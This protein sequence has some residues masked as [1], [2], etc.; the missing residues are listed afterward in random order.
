VVTRIVEGS[1]VTFSPDREQVSLRENATHEVLHAWSPPARTGCCAPGTRAAIFFDEHE[2]V[3]DWHCRD[4][5]LG[6]REDERPSRRARRP[7]ATLTV[8][9]HVLTGPTRKRRRAGYGAKWRGD[10]RFPR[11]E[12]KQ[13]SPRGLGPHRRLSPARAALPNLLGAL[14]RWHPLPACLGI[15]PGGLR[16]AVGVLALTPLRPAEAVQ[17]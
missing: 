16:R 15:S 2:R 10:I 14:P 17:K 12:R 8:R 11:L 1:I 13:S 9:G 6:T 3:I 5:R 4:E 7:L